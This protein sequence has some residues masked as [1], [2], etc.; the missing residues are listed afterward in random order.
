MVN[1]KKD[2][3]LELAEEHIKLAEDLVIEKAGKVDEEKAE[4]LMKVEFELERAEAE[5]QEISE[6]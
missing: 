5:L 6:E 4:K 3:D 1:K 2:E